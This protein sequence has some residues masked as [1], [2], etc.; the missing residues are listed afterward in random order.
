MDSKR[1]AASGSGASGTAMPAGASGESARP[2]PVVRL[3]GDHPVMDAMLVSVLQ[4][5]DAY[6]L[7][8]PPGIRNR[9]EF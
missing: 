8:R 9:A 5:L 3:L 2:R 1:A 7:V 4:H 6:D